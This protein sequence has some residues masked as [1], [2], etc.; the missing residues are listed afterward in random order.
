VLVVLAL[1]RAREGL[2]WVLLADAVFQL[3][4]TGMALAT[5]KGFVAVLPAVLGAVDVWA[6]LFLLRVA[7]MSRT[8]PAP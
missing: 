3:F 1:R 2:G 7:R 5:N 4:D 8:S 6:G